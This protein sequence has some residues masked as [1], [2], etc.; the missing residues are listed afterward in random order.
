MAAQNRNGSNQAAHTPASV[1]HCKRLAFCLALRNCCRRHEL[2]FEAPP[3]ARPLAAPQTW[4]FTL[5][6]A[7]APSAL[8]VHAFLRAVSLG[9]LSLLREGTRPS[10]PGSGRNFCPEVP[11]GRLGTVRE[12]L[13]KRKWPARCSTWRP[14]RRVPTPAMATRPGPRSAKFLPRV[15]RPLDP[16]AGP[17]RAV[18]SRPA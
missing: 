3:P 2:G 15:Q 13:T 6:A 17:E 12:G 10:S 1:S 7:A 4:D 14:Q 8:A 5:G 9:R 11:G 18:A 16:R